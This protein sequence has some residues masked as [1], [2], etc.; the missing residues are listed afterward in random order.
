MANM[1]EKKRTFSKRTLVLTECAIMVALAT[2]L[3]LVKL[4]EMPLGGSVTLLSMLPVM[5]IAMRH[6][7]G[8][9]LGTAFV[10]SVGQLFLGLPSLMSWGM[11]PVMWVG[12]VVF[13]YLLAFTL[14]GLAGLFCKKGVKGAILGVIFACFLRFV[15]HFI[16]GSIFFAIWSPWDNP[17]WYSVC[18]NGA[19]MGVELLLVIVG[20]G[21][22]F[23][24]REMRKLAGLEAE[25]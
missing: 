11:T 25:A 15:S 4:W 20:A 3:S 21:L 1:M 18:Y 23:A 13:D 17:V 9:G 6:G 8:V 24:S 19:Y 5:L 2:V 12:S 7:V 16:S 10:Y 22:L 14:L